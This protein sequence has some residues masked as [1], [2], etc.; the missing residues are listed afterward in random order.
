MKKKIALL[1]VA[2][3]TAASLAACS[4]TNNTNPTTAAPTAAQTDAPSTDAPGT[5]APETDAPETQAP[6]E[7]VT[8]TKI[9]ITINPQ[10][11]LQA[12]EDG[13]I[14]GFEYLNEDAQTAYEGLELIGK[15]IAEASALCVNAATEKGFMQE[16]KEVALTLVETDMVGADVLDA[17][18]EIKNSTLDELNELEFDAA[19]VRVDIAH[20]EE[21]IQDLT[22]DLCFGFGAIVCD[23]CGGTTFLDGNAWTVCEKCEGNGGTNC[24][25]C[26]G[27]TSIPCDGCGG[28]GID[29]NSNACMQ[30]SGSGSISCV[31]CNGVGKQVCE[32]CNGEG[33]LGGL[34][35]PRCGG[36][37]LAM[38]NRCDG[39]GERI[40]R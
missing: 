38:C 25:L 32:D 22:C 2:A 37:L 36:T 27:A 4:Q 16:G 39:T 17:V 40:E 31:R 10:I 26:E 15:T 5:E 13:I 30:C 6:V 21:D 14:T 20:D 9:N 35:C 8:G 29:S 23:G 1:L 28:T 19:Y 11:D 34:P 7:K 24:T 3:L 33:R 18:T 12:D